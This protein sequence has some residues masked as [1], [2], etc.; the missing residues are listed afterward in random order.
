VR[1]QGYITIIPPIFNPYASR[2]TEEPFKTPYY[3]ALLVLL[4]QPI[5]ETV[6]EDDQPAAETEPIGKPVLEDFWK[7]FQGF[8]D[9]QSWRELRLSVRPL[10][11]F[12]SPPL[13]VIFQIHFFAHLAL[14]NIVSPSSLL[15]LLQSFATVLD[16]PGVSYGRALKAGLCV[17]EGLLRVSSFPISPVLCAN[18]WR[19]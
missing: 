19:A 11:S 14:A 8:L 9:N 4:H 17:G 12:I 5:P 16:E 3:A 18:L 6:A 10:L 1:S 13:T 15:A 7:G 2:V